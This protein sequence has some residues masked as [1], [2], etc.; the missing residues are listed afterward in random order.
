MKMIKVYG[1]IAIILILINFISCKKDL[2]RQ[3]D[4]LYEEKRL[5]EALKYYEKFCEIHKKTPQREYALYRIGLILAEIGEC[6]KSSKTFEDLIKNFPLSHYRKEAE[7]RMIRCPNYFYSSYKKLYYG[8]SQ[9]YGKNAREEIIYTHKDFKKI[10]F[11]S[12]IYSGTKLLAKNNG[13]IIFNNTDVIEKIN[14]RKKL[15]FTYTPYSNNEKNNIKFKMEDV[16]ELEV[17]AGKF[18]NCIK[19]IT[20]E[21]EIKIAN[22]YAPETGRILT[23]AISQ[24]TEKRIMELIK[25]E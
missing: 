22:Y 24:G 13:E 19:V 6:K 8:D 23:S 7:F 17:K 25:Y 1:K 4:K 15:I 18:Y 20:N 3:A 12:R 14:G 11:I 2:L 10:G 9:S 5:F 16:K 21:G